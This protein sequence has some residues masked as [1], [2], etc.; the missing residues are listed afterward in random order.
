MGD[1]K[2]L[3]GRLAAITPIPDMAPPIKQRIACPVCGK[4]RL[5]DWMGTPPQDQFSVKT[6]CSLCGVV[7]I[8]SKHITKCLTLE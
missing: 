3:V 6:K 2:T 4:R 5:F 1:V 7:W 8:T